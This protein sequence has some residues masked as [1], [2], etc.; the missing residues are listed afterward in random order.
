MSTVIFN[1]YFGFLPDLIYV[2]TVSLSEGA[3]LGAHGSCRTEKK[4]IEAT[5]CL[6][7]PPV[8]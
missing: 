8:I 7:R 2:H 4:N 3:A 5:G 6:Q 1:L